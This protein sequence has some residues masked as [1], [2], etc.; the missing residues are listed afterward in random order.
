MTQ[1]LS[2]SALLEESKRL[3]SH[4][5]SAEIP[6]VKRGIDLLESESRK[7]VA[8]S[9]R[10]GRPL[11]PRAQAML[12]SAGVDTD[13]LASNSASAALLSAFELLQPAYDANVA[14]FLSQQQE[15]SIINAIEESELSTLDDFDRNM[16][17]HMNHVWEDTQCRLFEELGQFQGAASSATAVFVSSGGAHAYSAPAIRVTATTHPR[18]DR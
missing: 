17:A 18:L 3:T 2:L 9:A 16:A 5:T 7:L 15:Q 6:T 11:D 10:D 14:S 1:P 12:A 8:R 13:E 4:L